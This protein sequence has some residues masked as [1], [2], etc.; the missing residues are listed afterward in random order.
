VQLLSTF[1]NLGNDLQVYKYSRFRSQWNEWN[2]YSF[3]NS[4]FVN[5][6]DRI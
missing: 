3:V 4:D 6:K 1:V 2:Y 5:L